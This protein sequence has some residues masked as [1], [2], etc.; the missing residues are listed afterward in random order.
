MRRRGSRPGCWKP[1][2][3]RIGEEELASSAQSVEL[4]ET[5]CWRRAGG[6]ARLQAHLA[7]LQASAARF[8][9]PIAE[10]SIIRTLR[11]ADAEYR[12]AGA[13]VLRVRLVVSGKGVQV[14]CSAMPEPAA[15]PQPV[16]LAAM[17]VRADDER[18]RH[19][20][21]DR[22]IYEEAAASVPEGVEPLL[23]NTD[24]NVTESGIAN[25]IYAWEGVRYTPPVSD[26]LL[27]GVFRQMLLDRGEIRERSLPVCDLVAVQELYLVNALRGWRRARL[28]PA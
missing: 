21:T 11:Q 2:A 4:L 23:W 28:L 19:K 25:L 24:G 3:E 20:T 8:A 9:L 16:A 13:R 12:A 7:R 18:L 26:G 22:R 6:F 10:A 27:P 5:L 1:A 14:A 17:P 15:H